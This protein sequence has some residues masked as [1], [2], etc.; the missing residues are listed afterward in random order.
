MLSKLIRTVAG[1]SADKAAE[2]NEMAA[3]TLRKIEKETQEP[4]EPLRG[5]GS[6]DQAYEGGQVMQPLPKPAPRHDEMRPQ[7]RVAIHPVR[8]MNKVEMRLFNWL[9]DKL[10]VEAPLYSIHAQVSMDAFL[11]VDRRASKQDQQSTRDSFANRRVDFLIADDLGLPVLAIEFH[12]ADQSKEEHGQDKASALDEAG[13]PLV[14]IPNG[15]KP[16]MI[17]DTIHPHLDDED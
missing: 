7:Q 3:I 4:Q 14:V 12:G 2:A 6:W 9:F 8:M 15:A 11:H 17:W 16:S 5:S 1:N 13:V 10:E